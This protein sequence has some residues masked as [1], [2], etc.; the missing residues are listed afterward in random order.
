MTHPS[1]T[2][3][4]IIKM[5]FGILESNNSKKYWV[6]LLPVL[7]LT[8]G[9]ILH[10]SRGYYGIGNSALFAYGVDDAYITY[11]YGW[12]LANFGILSWN[13]S[14]YRLAEGFTNPLWM[15]VS[16]VWSLL[17]IKTLV[18]PLSVITSV[19]VSGFFLLI[20]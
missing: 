5:V 18:Y 20:L 6:I 19:V 2:I 12:N 3:K 4:K 1:R 13:E 9:S 10:Y 15:L 14:G 16:A 7:V 17:G 8:L 11:R